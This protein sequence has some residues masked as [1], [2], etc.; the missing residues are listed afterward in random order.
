MEY[1]KTIKTREIFFK[2]PQCGAE[3]YSLIGTGKGPRC[4]KCDTYFSINDFIKVEKEVDAIKCECGAAILIIDENFNS[5]SPFRELLCPKHDPPKSLGIFYRGKWRP[6]NAFFYKKGENGIKTATS[7]RD[8]ITAYLLVREA[9]QE[10]K[11]FNSPRNWSIVRILWDNGEAIGYYMHNIC[12]GYPILNQIY[13]RP[14][15]RRKGYG[16][17]LVIDSLQIL[18]NYTTIAIETPNENS[19]RL[20]EKL[21]LVRKIK[22]EYRIIDS[23]LKFVNLG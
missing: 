12:H 17:K 5:S 13:V 8:K 4:Y 20:L 16:T 11:Y 19:L 10:I 1:V 22:D 3:K 15:F 6:E 23:R 18:K 2:C 9:Q 14:Q 21:G 7:Q